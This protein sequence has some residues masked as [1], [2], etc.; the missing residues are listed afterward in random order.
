MW[1]RRLDNKHTVFGNV[2]KGMGVVNSI[3]QNDEIISIT[4]NAVGEKIKNL[5][6]RCF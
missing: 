6:Q 5:I 2:I 3:S 4:I 1:K